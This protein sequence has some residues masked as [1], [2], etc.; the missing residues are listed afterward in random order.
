MQRGATEASIQV[1]GEVLQ[2]L[3]H[4]INVAFLGGDQ[5]RRHLP[6]EINRLPAR[7]RLGTCIVSSTHYFRQRPFR[8][9]LQPAT[10]ARSFALLLACRPPRCSRSTASTA[11][12]CSS[13]AARL[14]PSL[15][16]RSPAAALSSAALSATAFASPAFFSASS[17]T[18]SA[19]AF[20][21]AAFLSLP[22]DA[23]P[24]FDPPLPLRR[25]AVV[26]P[27]AR[28]PRGLQALRLPL[29]PFPERLRRYFLPPVSSLVA[30]LRLPLHPLNDGGRDG[31]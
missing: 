21:S 9:T 28:T 16:P 26:S 23:L 24:P 31:G 29:R 3:F 2:V 30:A 4:R 17:A 13:G 12:L 7:S 6:V 10:A 25:P 1:N 19:T 20:A 8:Q 27:D 11:S 15:S 22:L 5:V 14:L 18:L